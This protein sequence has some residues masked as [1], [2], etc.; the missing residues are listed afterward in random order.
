MVKYFIIIYLDRSDILWSNIMNLCTKQVNQDKYSQGFSINDEFTL[1]FYQISTGSLQYNNLISFFNSVKI[2]IDDKII[3]LGHQYG[4]TDHPGV[5]ENTLEQLKG[6]YSNLEYRLFTSGESRSYPCQLLRCINNSVKN[7]SLDLNSLETKLQEEKITLDWNTLKEEVKKKDIVKPISILKHKIMHIFLPLDIDLQSISKVKDTE[8]AVNYLKDMLW[9]VLSSKNEPSFPKDKDNKPAY[10]RQKLAD[11]WYAVAKVEDENFAH[12]SQSMKEFVNEKGS[13][14][15][16]IPEDKKEA[17]KS[18][19][20]ELLKVCGLKQINGSKIQADSES[21]IYQFVCQI[22][23]FV[24]RM[25]NLL[26]ENKDVKNKD[27]ITVKQE[28]LNKV[29]N[30]DFHKQYKDLDNCLEKIREI[31][32]NQ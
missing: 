10:Y 19:L 25:D 5:E 22:Y 18:A 11:L 24:C 27:E 7:N 16:L 15:D 29:L 31:I 17:V 2:N 1:Y 32:T 28:D 12:P 6:Q 3:I 20:E 21:S 9:S 30:F 14:V 4:G 23:Q 13:V 8:K 26:Y